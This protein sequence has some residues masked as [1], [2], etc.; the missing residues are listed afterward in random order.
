MAQRTLTLLEATGIQ[1]YI[2]G[3]NQLAQNIGASELVTLSTTKWLVNKLDKIVGSQS[4]N[5]G[6]NGIRVTYNGRSLDDGLQAEVVYAGGGNAMLLFTDKAQAEQFTKQLTAYLLEYARGLQLVVAHHHD[7]DWSNQSLA[8][9]HEKLRGKLAARKLDRAVSAPLLGLGVTAG[10]VYTGLPAVGLDT[11]PKIVGNEAAKKTEYFEN[12]DP[13]LVSSEVADKLCVEN[14][15]KERLHLI[16]DTVRDEWGYEFIYD[17]DEL[18]SKD[19]SSYLAV[20]HADGNQMGER[21][22]QMAKGHPN[23]A[24]NG[25]Y[26]TTLRNYS[27]TLQE[28]S[29]RAL[30]ATVDYLFASLDAGDGT[31]KFGGIVPT[32]KTKGGEPLLPFRPIVFG[33]DDVTFVCDGRLGLSLAAKYLQEFT[34]LDAPEGDLEGGPVY[35]RAGVAVVKNHYPFSRAYELAERLAQHAKTEIQKG[36]KPINEPSATVIDW[37]FATTGMVFDIAEIREREYMEKVNPKTRQVTRSLQM[38]PLLMGKSNHTWRNWDNFGRLMR[39]FQDKDGE[40]AGKRN[41]MKALRDALR[42]ENVELFLTNYSLK[43]LPKI[44]GAK[45]MSS[46]GWQS[47]RC[48]Y[49]DAIEATDYFVSLDQEEKAGV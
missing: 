38:R 35:A 16:L 25:S 3:S 13:R 20:I 34:R 6:W 48:G 2:F 19:E 22:K 1:D 27:Q 31:G 4:H 12:Y 46:S 37:H 5:A 15:G 17:F 44:T 18:G 11:D 9:V 21:F 7:F 49:F 23:P 29:R 39:D 24:D 43:Q 40:W 45:E 10:C 30:K 41:K 32:P 8:T 47:G 26:I 14:D 36:L 42:G 28:K 33:G